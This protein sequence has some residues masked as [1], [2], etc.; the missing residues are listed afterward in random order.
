MGWVRWFGVMI[1][2]SG[3]AVALLGV[4]LYGVG[5]GWFGETE[6]AGEIRGRSVH[7]SI[8]GR[9]AQLQ[10]RAHESLDVGAHAEKQILFGD[11]HVHTTFSFDAFLLGLPMLGGEGAHPPAD[12]CDFARHCSAL[13]FYSLNDHAEYLTPELWRESVESV[14]QCNAVA[15]DPVNPDL[16]SYLGWEWSQIGTTPEQH[17]GHKNVVLLSTGDA[18][19]PARPIA[20]TTPG[21]ATDGGPFP[22]GTP[23]ALALL[24]GSR[25]RDFARFL[26]NA[27][28][29][30]ACPRGVPVREL[31]E[32][33]REY[34]ETP[35]VLFDK[36]ADWGFE[37]L[38][39]PHGT[40]WGIYT[41]AGSDW[42]QQLAGHDPKRQR[43]VEIYSGHGSS[44]AY[45]AWRATRVA[46]DG[47]LSCPEPSDGY[48][49]SCWRAGVL[50]R[51][52]CLEVG[53]GADECAR[54]E[55]QARQNYVDARNGGWNT[56]P[57]HGPDHW[58]DSGQC[59]DCFQTAFNHRPAG[60]AQY[61]LAVRNFDDP[62]NPRRFK[63]GFMASSDIHTAKPGSGYKE[64]W[65]GEMTEGRGTDP[66]T[67]LPSFLI[68]EPG[69]PVSE[70]V[71]FDLATQEIR[72]MS[73][74]ENERANSF[75]YTGGLVAV[76]SPGRDRVS[77][78][79]SLKRREVYGTSGPRIL[80]WFDLL[81][82]DGQRV[83]MGASVR[84]SQTPRFR[85][86]AVGSFEQSEGCP[87]H[88]IANLGAERL[89]DLCRGE[90]Y[91]PSDQRR[92]ITRIEVVRI[93]P[94]KHEHEPLAALIDDPFL[95][96]ACPPD[97]AGCSLEFEDPEFAAAG[98]DTVYYVRAIEQQSIAIHGSNPLGC[99]FDEAGVCSEVEPCGVRVPKADD[100]LTPTEQRAWSSPIFVD[101]GS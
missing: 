12:A 33:C 22:A 94:Q 95:T 7:A 93:R 59:N 28:S 53:E 6:G 56:A 89:A 60:S 82:G 99:R 1:G 26:A 41:P 72:G 35:E 81:E 50:I 63:F 100:C 44:E 24:N 2:G 37:S 21:F 83:P 36:L 97:P 61:M 16:V 92:L 54:R 70:S 69:E 84:R 86:N 90:C 38:V 49:P 52:R 43:L 75:F 29:V 62:E 73:Y 55:Q 46:E 79:D 78:F 80:L 66:E 17:H 13:D 101:H 67:S 76:H 98:R 9:R 47:S 15:G 32:D 57:G 74:F 48:L 34:A 10:R 64:F 87:D 88:A 23:T 20:A 8:V 85:V 18:R 5:A 77:I 68:P 71:R 27:G 65:R 45:R 30:P 40:S 19:I 14:R 4:W 11:L 3:V 96:L 25:G 58:L 51:E 31:P 42:K 39:I 91:N